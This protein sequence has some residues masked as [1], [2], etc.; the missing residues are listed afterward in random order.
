MHRVSG[1]QNQL[2]VTGATRRFDSRI[3]LS[4]VD[5]SLCPGEIFVLL[6]PNGAGKTTLLRAIAG[7]L[8]LDSGT[9]RI[10]GRDPYADLKVRRQLGVVPQSIAIYPYMT[11]RENLEV[12]GVLASSRIDAAM[13]AVRSRYAGN[14][15]ILRINFFDG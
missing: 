11:A 1:K 2:S 9:V 12:F 7:R 10:D 8:R 14:T 4:N 5:L 13:P 6:G 3:A 15:A